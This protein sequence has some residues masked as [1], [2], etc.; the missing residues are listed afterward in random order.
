[1]DVK[2]TQLFIAFSK[3]TPD[4]VVAKW[5]AALDSM[6]ADGSFDAIVKKYL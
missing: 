6:K 5:Q 1:M 2:E 4:D 3:N